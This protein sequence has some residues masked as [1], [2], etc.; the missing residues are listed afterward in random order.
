MP[1]PLLALNVLLAGVSLVCVAFIVQQL[2]FSSP[3]AP[4]GRPRPPDAPGGAPPAPRAAPRL[5]ATAYTVVAARNVFSPT[6]TEATAAAPGGGPALA[7]VRLN[8]HGVVLRDTNPI[9]YLEDPLTK[10][11]AGYRVGDQIAGGTLKTIAADR[12]VIARPEGT[13]DVR[14]RDPLKP[15]PA[16]PAPAAP[17]APGAPTVAPPP[18][19]A[20]GASPALVPPRVQ[21]QPP[22]AQFPGGAPQIGPFIPG[23]RPSPSLGSRL[24]PSRPGDVAPQPQQ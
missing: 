9:A 12:V 22:Q 24:P 1:R 8:L 2:A 15:R 14:L 23:R 6:R 3:A 20:P 19:A 16:S 7:V 13:V 21:A 4:P 11:V 18:G 5:P 10:R 17:V